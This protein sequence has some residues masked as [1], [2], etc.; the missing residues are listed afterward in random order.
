M[1]KCLILSAVTVILISLTPATAQRKEYFTEGEIDL[2][3]D[4]QELPMRMSV[5]C[6]LADLRLNA[7]EMKEKTAKEKEAER[8]AEEQHRKEVRDAQRAGKAAPKAE[9]RPDVYL[10]DFT[11]A[12]L[13]SGY[14]EAIDEAM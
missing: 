4:A 1:P 6:R 11:R 5:L 7:L 3:R 9:E 10:A 12:E 13:L 14:T 2:I 8:K